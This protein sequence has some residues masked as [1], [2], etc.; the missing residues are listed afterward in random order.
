MWWLAAAAWAL[1]PT[2]VI[3]SELERGMVIL[4]QQETPPYYVA[5]TVADH[6][7]V[8]VLGSDGALRSSDRSRSRYLDVE[9]RTGSPELDNT[10]P[11]RGF[12]S[13]DEDERDTRRIPFEGPGEERA[14]RVALAME[15]DRSYREAAER[16]EL[17][18]GEEVVRVEEEDPA[19][20]FEL[21]PGVVDARPTPELALD[22]PAWEALLAELSGRM[23]IS[24]EVR[25]ARAFLSAS[26][27]VWTVVDTEGARLTHGR[28]H[29]RVG[30]SASAVADDGDV[31]EVFDAVDVHTADHLPAAAALQAMADAVA[32]RA[33]ALRR[34]P[35]A[36]PYTGPVMLSGRATGVFF[37]E[38]MGHRVE[39]QRQ[40]SDDEGKTFL[41]YVGKPVLP[42]WLDVYDDPNLAALAGADL[43]GHYAYDDQG[44][45]AQR[46]TLVEDGVFR[47]FLMSRSPLAGFPH[48]NGHGRRS[49]GH[50]PTARMGN[51]I[52][53]SSKRLSVDELRAL[54]RKEAVAQGLPY[55]YLVEEIDGGFTLT[56]RVIPNAFNV[57]AS[58]TWRV[59][60]DGRPDELVRGIDLVGTPLVAFQNLIA[61]GGEPEVF[62]GVCGAESGWVPVSAVAPAV[63]FRRLEFQLKEK[64]S[65]RP[66][67]L[68]PPMRP[69]GQATRERAAG[70]AR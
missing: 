62:N 4:R 6:E 53:E 59:Y 65:D 9:V 34:A 42:P 61:A 70:G 68:T 18:R 22:R 43:N 55:A 20:D 60:T 37:H 1:D 33:V 30:F 19:P 41:E 28:V 66:P 7:Q 16:L 67:L 2:A 36:G 44:V 29:L 58:V 47:G 51:T 64:D 15:L 54:L 39:G 40:K 24:P 3:V 25:E 49:P 38:V 46:A 35:R 27:D 14:L 48:S 11:L 45:P 52:I 21:R 8:D 31:V 17:V 50:T 12:S 10:H 23:V 63:V 5:I 32:T 57:Q 69:S 26:R 13:L 56:G